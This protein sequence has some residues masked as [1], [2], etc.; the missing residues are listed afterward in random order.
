MPTFSHFMGHFFPPKPTFT[1]ANLPADLSGKVYIV[2]GSNSGIG[3][4]VSR[5]LYAKDA[6]VYVLCRSKEK[7]LEAISD[8]KKATPNSKG[9]LVFI[10]CDL[11]DL[12]SVKTAAEAFLAREKRLDVL[13]NNAGVVR[14]SSLHSS[15]ASFPLINLTFHW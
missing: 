9:E 7:A 13:F 6:K 15:H 11:A 12:N 14:T 8:I 4:D 3:K 5:L 1:D 2:T 10:A